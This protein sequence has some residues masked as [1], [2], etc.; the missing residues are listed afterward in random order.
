MSDGD[1]IDF[2]YFFESF[3]KWIEEVKDLYQVNNEIDIDITRRESDNSDKGE[4]TED[5]VYRDLNHDTFDHS[6]DEVFP[7]IPMHHYFNFDFP[8]NR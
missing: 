1:K 4:L 6:K 3:C 8:E 5:E 7:A 2:E